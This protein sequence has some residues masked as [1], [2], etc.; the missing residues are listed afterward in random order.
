MVTQF[1]DAV[2]SHGQWIWQIVNCDMGKRVAS[3]MI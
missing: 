1:D 3:D 2:S